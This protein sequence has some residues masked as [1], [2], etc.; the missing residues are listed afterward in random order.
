[1]IING[2]EHKQGS[3]DTKKKKNN[4]TTSSKTTKHMVIPMPSNLKASHSSNGGKATPRTF[5]ELSEL[6][7]AKSVFIKPSE[8]EEEAERPTSILRRRKKASEEGSDALSAVD[9]DM[10]EIKKQRDQYLKS[11]IEEIKNEIH[12]SPEVMAEAALRV[13]HTKKKNPTATEK[14]GY[15]DFYKKCPEKYDAAS[16]ALLLRMLLMNVLQEE[17]EKMASTKDGEQ[18]SSLELGPSPEIAFTHAS[19]LRKKAKDKERWLFAFQALSVFLAAVGTAATVAA[20]YLAAHP[21]C[22]STICSP[23]NCTAVG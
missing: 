19:I 6:V 12:I 20:T 3:D 2:M 17:Q 18:E 7:K 23:C 22:P 5:D 21:N 1:M 15:A 8:E 11:K 9:M 10:Q 13:H 16:D 14:E 4:L